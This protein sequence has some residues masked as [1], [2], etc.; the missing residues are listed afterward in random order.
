V[1]GGSERRSEAYSQRRVL[2]D[3]KVVQKIA[4]RTGLTQAGAEMVAVCG[5][6]IQA[7]P[8]LDEFVLQ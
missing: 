8:R 1:A 7:T 6:N 3:G 4:G 2:E 5:N